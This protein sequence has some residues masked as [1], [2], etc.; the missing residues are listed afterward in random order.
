MIDIINGNQIHIQNAKITDSKYE[1]TF[2]QYYEDHNSVLILYLVLPGI[3]SDSI[4][5]YVS[6]DKIN[7]TAFFVKEYERM[8]QSKKILIEG[9]L[10]D[11]VLSN[12]F[13]IVYEAGIAKITFIVDSEMR[14]SID[15]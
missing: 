13:S 4:H 11:Y 6:G 2:H 9:T 8:F 1:H 7:L 5:L 14:N 10:K 15:I 12:V 3:R